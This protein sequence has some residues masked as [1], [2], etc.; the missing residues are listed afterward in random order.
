MGLFEILALVWAIILAFLLLIPS[1]GWVRKMLGYLQLADVAAAGYTLHL[2]AA[3]G[4]VGGLILGIW[5]ALG[6]S[7]TLRAL[8]MLIGYEKLA[9]NGEESIRLVAAELLTQGVRWVRALVAALFK[10]GRVVA[11]DPLNVEW[12]V[13]QS[14]AA[15]RWGFSF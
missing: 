14:P 3:T 10:G 9:V 8:K 5:A 2:T 7:L 15:Q 6:I 12:V 1:W 4:T 13:H 11:P